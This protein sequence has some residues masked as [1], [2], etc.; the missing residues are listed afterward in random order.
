MKKMILKILA[1]IIS[2]IFSLG[3]TLM[4]KPHI[5]VYIKS[6][7]VL[8]ILNIIFTFIGF[9]VIYQVL[10][11]NLLNRTVKTKRTFK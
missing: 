3:L 7:I 10:N 5:G 1:G 8:N 2:I 11:K 4:I 6:E 9:A